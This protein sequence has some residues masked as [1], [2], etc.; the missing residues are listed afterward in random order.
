MAIKQ[1]R[2]VTK[3]EILHAGMELFLT[4]G[5]K[6][7]V[8]DVADAAGVSRQ[9]VYQ[10]FHTRSGLLIA[11]TRQLDENSGIKERFYEAIEIVAPSQ[12]LSACLLIWFGHIEDLQVLANEFIRNRRSDPDAESAYT[13]RAADVKIWFSDLFFSLKEDNALKQGVHIK[14]AV[15]ITFTIISP[16]VYEL[17]HVDQQWPHGKIVDHLC[18]IISRTVMT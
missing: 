13:D 4:K 16:Q 1:A 17:L 15:D 10:Y 2:G 12:R 7:T 5:I 3:S 8:K 11:L 14:D 6:V 9:M 18:D